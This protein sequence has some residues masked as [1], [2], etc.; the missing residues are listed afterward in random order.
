MAATALLV[1]A[2]LTG[3]ITSN[4][5]LS[6]EQEQTAR[7]LQLARE[8]ERV[9]F[10]HLHVARI[11][12]AWNELNTSD[13][14]E[15]LAVLEEDIPPPGDEDLRSFAWQYV[16]TLCQ[17]KSQPLRTMT[18]HLEDVYCVVFSP[19]GRMLA[20]AGHDKTARLWETATGRLL[21]TLT[22]HK[23]DVNCVAFAPDG[24][25]L[26]TASDDGGI[27]LW[28]VSTRRE[29]RHFAQLPCKAAEV[30]FS[31]DGSMLAA[32]LDDGN[33]ARWELPSGKPLPTFKADTPIDKVESLAFSADGKSLAV[34][35]P[36]TTV[37]DV[38]TGTKRYSYHYG[39]SAGA[40]RAKCAAFSHDG[41]LLAIA[42]SRTVILI[43]A[44][45]G[46]E[47]T[48][49][50][51]PLGTAESVSFAPGDRILAS[52][53]DD[54]TT[55]LWDLPSGK[56]RAVLSAS[57][58]RIWGVAFSP[59]G[60]TLATAGRDGLVKLWP[61]DAHAT[62]ETLL[63]DGAPTFVQGPVFSP[64][65]KRFATATFD[66]N[67]QVW[68][69]DRIQKEFVIPG[70]PGLMAFSPDGD[71]LAVSHPDATV[72]IWDLVRR[73]ERVRLRAQSATGSTPQVELGDLTYSRDGRSLLAWDKRTGSSL[74]WDAVSGDCLGVRKSVGMS[75]AASFLPNRRQCLFWSGGPPE[76]PETFPNIVNLETGLIRSGRPLDRLRDIFC[77]ALSPDGT[78]F[79]VA[80]T[81][82]RVRL[83]DTATLEHRATLLHHDN[84]YAAAFSADSKTLATGG[85]DGIVRLWNVALGQELLVLEA[86]QVPIRALAFS[87]DGRTLTSSYGVSRDHLG[88]NLWRTD[89]APASLLVNTTP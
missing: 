33:V 15:V 36:S 55:R 82:R 48:T 18:G 30:A 26:A 29:V 57:S 59:D 12:H 9:A 66:G 40:D 2:G 62:Y 21:A 49:L 74:V 19:D 73:Q 52:A 44:V 42:R 23:D 41:R 45:S 46:Q 81:D 16:H 69:T 63:S 86:Q 31:P 10:L 53:G 80:G 39:A 76:K 85:E 67:V 61:S 14:K 22:G 1:V 38:P 34:C 25:T 43:D 5:L 24:R 84:V 35:A 27:K 79:A 89:A 8:R 58:S 65:G 68:L 17:R 87:P 75:C 6:R 56:P 77:T 4:V 83:V 3:L 32:G 47:L 37:W 50:T 60:L 11:R 70:R 71:E 64:D 78:V 54:G 88:I 20:T 28:D 72:F 51:G 7:A 13:P